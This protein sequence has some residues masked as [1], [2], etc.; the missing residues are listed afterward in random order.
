MTNTGADVSE[1]HLIEAVECIASYFWTGAHWERRADGPHLV[2]EP[3]K[4]QQHLARHLNGGP[5]VG[6]APII[7]GT[8]ETRVLVFDLDSHKGEANW[9]EVCRV[10]D[11]I[12]RRLRGRGMNPFAFRSSGGKGIHVYVLFSAAVDAYSA[13]EFARQILEACGLGVGTKGVKA[14]CVEI[15][16]KA[17]EV[18]VNGVGSMVIL[19]LANESLPLD[20]QTLEVISFE[21][22]EASDWPE[23]PP[24]PK[25]ERPQPVQQHV[26]ELSTD[27]AELRSQ[28]QAIPNEGD[29]PLD[30]DEWFR[31]VAAI[32]HATNGS[33]EGSTLAHEFSA[34]SSKYN[35]EFLDEKVWR[36]LRDD[37]GGGKVITARTVAAMARENGWQ[38]DVLSEFEELPPEQETGGAVSDSAPD[39]ILDG[40]ALAGNRYVFLP[41]AKFGSQTPSDFIV[42]G[43]LPRSGLVLLIGQSTAGKS[44]VALDLAGAVA[45]GESWRGHKVK[46]SRVAI[47]AAEG[48]GG[49]RKRLVAYAQHQGVE[50]EHLDI[51]V[52]ADTPNFLHKDDVKEVVLALNALGQINVLIIDTLAQVTPGGDENSAKDMGAAL[53]NCKALHQATGATVVLVHHVGKDQAKG[54]RGW[55]GIKAAADAE[56]VVTRDGDARSV[57]I[58]KMKD[59]QDG[60]AFP[61]KLTVVPI[62]T[63]S[64][65]D[66]VTSCVVEH[67]DEAPA[68]RQEPKGKW[69]AK[70]WPV[71]N[72]LA[73]L[74]DG[75][76]PYDAVVEETIR[77]EPEATRSPRI[78][79]LVRQGLEG[80]V[81]ARLVTIDGNT[82]RPLT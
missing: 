23:S 32:H 3:L 26:G 59:G 44:F 45:R 7:P 73:D 76:A 1:Q 72:D 64:D 56:L 79:E 78:R 67:L 42:K 58:T 28:L 80:L 8:S 10:G 46:K 68:K 31:I 54:A 11:G 70:L 77:R 30:Y 25:L 16:P 53:A 61:F 5:A 55:S 17:D 49:F 39:T 51:S 13:R 63:D 14:G 35:P 47:I 81:G 43:V 52:L 48:A 34:R 18:S 62:G 22:V 66:T 74:G 9:G 69:Q 21:S 82:I 38:A 2:R 60:L 57:E 65:G 75:G 6:L 40:P 24:V 4:P 27:L 71:I 50:L 36:Y 12:M 20:S 33:A 19:P 37:R 15:F 41:A 29:K